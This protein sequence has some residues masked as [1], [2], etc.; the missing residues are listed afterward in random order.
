MGI[1]ACIRDKKCKFILAKSE[2]FS[3]LLDVD[4]AKVLGLPDAM[5]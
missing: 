5:S 3:P 4:T 1:D 2:W